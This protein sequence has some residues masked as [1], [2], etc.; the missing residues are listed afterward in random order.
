MENILYDYHLAQ[1][2]GEQTEAEKISGE[3]GRRYNEH[4]YVYTALKKHGMTLEDFDKA[5]EWYTRT[6]NTLLKIYHRLE[7]RLAEETGST[8]GDNAGYYTTDA[9]ADTAD[10]WLNKRHVLLSSNIRQYVYFEQDMDTLAKCGDR[11][12]WTLIPNWYYR[13]G[14]RD[15]VMQMTLV[16]EG[17]STVTRRYTIQRSGVQKIIATVD[18]MPLRKIRA[19]VYQQ[20]VWNARPS[21]LE[22]NNISLVRFRKKDDSQSTEDL[23]HPHDSLTAVP[24]DSLPA[25]RK[26][27]AD[28]QKMLRD[29]LYKSDSIRRNSHHFKE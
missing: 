23:S 29:S 7:E 11:L 10:I 24:I 1:A 3:A 26:L 12:E 22:L 4:Y 17:D 27:P 13:E 6:P 15:A 18:S 20:S 8:T 9:S 2:M 16:Y 5:M 28:R 14:R 19:F 21:F 25:D